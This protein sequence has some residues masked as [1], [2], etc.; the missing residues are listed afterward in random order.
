MAEQKAEPRAGEI[1][2]F[3]QEHAKS[4]TQDNLYGFDRAS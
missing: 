4:F 1:V 3:Y 2:A